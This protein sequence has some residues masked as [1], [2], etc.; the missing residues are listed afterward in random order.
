MQL[1]GD[2]IILILALLLIVFGANHLSE[3][4]KGL[5]H[6]LFD[7]RK[8]LKRMFQ[9]ADDAATEAG[10][11]LGGIYGKAAAQA[12]AQDN[13]VAELYDPAVLQN[14]SEPHMPRNALLKFFMK[15]CARLRL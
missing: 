14:E 6:G 11:S 1:G 12:I 13:Q 8:L 2:E 7:F 3:L 15:V 5:G 10:R 9:S 4:A